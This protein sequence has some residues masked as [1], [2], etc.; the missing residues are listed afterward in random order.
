[1]TTFVDIFGDKLG[2]TMEQNWPYVFLLF[3][4]YLLLYQ[5]GLW[6]II[7]T[8]I[9]QIIIMGLM[10]GCCIVSWV[11]ISQ[12]I[13][14][15]SAMGTASFFSGILSFILSMFSHQYNLK[16]FACDNK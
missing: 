4:V 14:A 1:M 10:A 2:Q 13:D 8:I 16:I 12:H 3:S 9:K 7:S 6:K 15:L 5:V 11:L